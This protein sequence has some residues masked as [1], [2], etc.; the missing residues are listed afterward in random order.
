MFTL[1]FIRSS[2]EYM[3][4]IKGDFSKAASVRNM[5]VQIWFIK[6]SW[7][8]AVVG[9]DGWDSHRTK[10]EAM[11]TNSA[12]FTALFNIGR[13]DA[14]AETPILWPPD[15]KSQLIGKDPDTRKY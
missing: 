7:R 15:A 4:I 8:V 14:E 3:D 9:V 2:A 13:P 6:V 11:K 10:A 12:N 5:K 1:I